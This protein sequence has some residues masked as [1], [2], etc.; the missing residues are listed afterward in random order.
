MTHL[1]P[2][3]T[4]TRVTADELHLADFLYRKAALYIMNTTRTQQIAVLE[5]THAALVQLTAEL[6]DD[7]LDFHPAADEWSIREILAHLVDDEMYVMRTRLERI[8]KEDMP[9]LTPNDEKKWYATRNTTRDH[10]AELLNDF[11]LQRAASL[12]IMSMLREEDWARR[13]LQPEYGVFSA[14][15]W[16]KHWAEH[17]TVHIE[18]ISKTLEVYKR[19]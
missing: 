3:H 8:V 6:A 15:E 10:T 11:A 16:L 13:G 4:I 7:A 19:E 17:D 2:L 1:T 5:Q 9:T 14:E 18:Q 12:N